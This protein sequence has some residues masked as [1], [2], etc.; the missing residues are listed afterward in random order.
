MYGL[1]KLI[2]HS[3]VRM[4]MQNCHGGML[5]YQ[6]KH[7]QMPCAMTQHNLDNGSSDVQILLA[8]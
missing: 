1:S 8:A 5:G 2:C 6:K 4:S 7:Q 3:D